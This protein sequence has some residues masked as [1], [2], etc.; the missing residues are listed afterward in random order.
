LDGRVVELKRA[1]VGE[2]H[3]LQGVDNDKVPLI[4]MSCNFDQQLLMQ[5]REE[6]ANDL[7]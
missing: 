3:D 7:G 5:L 4:R 1:C 6:K 2:K